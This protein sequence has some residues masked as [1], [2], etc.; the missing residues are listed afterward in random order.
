M[1]KANIYI[2]G[3]VLVQNSLTRKFYIVTD[4]PYLSI[5][6][7]IVINCM[8]SWTKLIVQYSF[9]QEVHNGTLQEVL[10]TNEDEA[11]G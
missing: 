6:E 11:L 8:I 10:T 1:P 9:F 2:H 4:Q 3:K 5:S 7:Q